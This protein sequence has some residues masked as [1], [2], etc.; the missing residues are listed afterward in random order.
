MSDKPTKPS[1]T[2]AARARAASEEESSVRLLDYFH[3]V[4]E[5]IRPS[6]IREWFSRENLVAAA[7]TLAWVAPLTILIWVYAEREQQTNMGQNVLIEVEMPPAS[8]KVATIINPKD[9]VLMVELRGPRAQLDAIKSRLS[10]RDAVPPVRL[11]LEPNLAPDVHS[12]SAV[13]LLEQSAFFS[14]YGVRVLNSTPAMITFAVDEVQTVEIP[15]RNPPQATN[16]EPGTVF[17]PP[18]VKFTGPKN[19]IPTGSPESNPEGWRE[20]YVYPIGV[21]ELLRQTDQKEIY[22][23]NLALR[24]VFEADDVTLSPARVNATFRLKEEDVEYTLGDGRTLPVWLS[25]PPQ[26]LEEY[27]VEYDP[28]LVGVTF[29]G[30]PD[31]I[32]A[33]RQGTIMPPPK[34][35]IELGDSDLTGNVAEL[36]KPVK[37]DL[38]EGVRVA[39]KDQAKTVRVVLRRRMAD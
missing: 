21:V 14:E 36:N 25:H 6:N 17:D 7:K 26:L 31:V 18:T 13:P 16:I 15:V 27:E 8:G 28:V 9:K 23:E 34:A 22:L 3:G 33:I 19:L 30:R 35:R 32:E 12:L 37:Y 10:R 39:Q 38:P 1:Q 2:A 24:P 4:R 5:A 11:E 29:I 20:F